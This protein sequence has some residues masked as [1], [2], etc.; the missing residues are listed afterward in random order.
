[1]TSGSEEINTWVEVSKIIGV[2]VGLLVAIFGLIQFRINQR[3]RKSALAKELLEEFYSDEAL[4]CCRQILDWA[5]REIVIPTKY[6]SS[7]DASVLYYDSGDL[8]PA[9]LHE[10]SKGKFTRTQMFYRDI[11]DEFFAYLERIEHYL[12]IGL[13]ERRD[14]RA[15]KYWLRELAVPRFGPHDR[16]SVYLKFLDGYGYTG[17]LQLMQRFGVELPIEIAAKLPART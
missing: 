12:S 16:D 13:I 15:L 11:F 9:L 2:A 14:V 6:R 10:A 17:V 5:S 1:M 4:T 8:S 3:W 7:L